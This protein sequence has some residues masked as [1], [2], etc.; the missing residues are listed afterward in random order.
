MNQWCELNILVNFRAP[1]SNECIVYD[2][3]GVNWP[4]A[5]LDK[6]SS[7]SIAVLRIV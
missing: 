6:Y 2:Y 1:K 7:A 3:R 4:P 5:C